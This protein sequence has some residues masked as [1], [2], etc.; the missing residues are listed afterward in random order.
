[1]EATGTARA[2]GRTRVGT[3]VALKY[4]VPAAAT[5]MSR[6]GMARGYWMTWPWSWMR[7]MEAPRSRTSKKIRAMSTPMGNSQ[8]WPWP[9]ARAGSAAAS[10]RAKND[11]V[12]AAPATPRPSRRAVPSTVRRLEGSDDHISSGTSRSSGQVGSRRAGHGLA[13]GGGLLVG[14]VPQVGQ[15]AD[16]AGHAPDDLG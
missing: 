7:T 11:K 6:N 4:R 16:G 14:P 5:S 10:R 15:P 8:A 9:Q 1:M 2:R 12:K 3:W 13:P